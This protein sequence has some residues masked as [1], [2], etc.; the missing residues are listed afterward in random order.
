MGFLTQLFTWWNGQ[1]LNLRFFTWRNGE[2]VG[3][4]EAGNRYYRSPSAIPGSIAERRWV[5]YAG[6]AEASAVPPGWH[7]WMHHRVSEPP[8]EGNYRPHEW[9][10]PHNP[11]LTGTSHG[12][13]SAW[14]YCG[15]ASASAAAARLPS[16]EAGIEQP[17]WPVA[18]TFWLLCR[19]PP[20][21]TRAERRIDGNEQ[22]IC[23]SSG[24]RA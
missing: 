2:F 4:D 1:T 10:K 18:A 23:G 12:L 8:V 19:I 21:S 22:Y 13:S 15:R 9:E 6:Y 14:S 5:V 7:G 20:A 11:N 17:P 3:A 16:V 24:W